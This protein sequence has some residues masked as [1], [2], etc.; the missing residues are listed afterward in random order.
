MR[1][2]ALLLLI[3]LLTLRVWAG[4]AMAFAG[5]PTATAHLSWAASG[6]AQPP[7]HEASAL[8]LADQADPTQDAR[9][10]DH[11]GPCDAC[12]VC[13]LPLLAFSVQAC[14]GSPLPQTVHTA[15]AVRFQSAQLAKRLKPPIG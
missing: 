10:G 13:H 12:Q 14:T 8:P 7:C 4:D 2:P 1:R 6:H 5:L 11:N 3:C 15:L 9:S